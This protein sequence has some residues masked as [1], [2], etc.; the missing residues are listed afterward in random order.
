MVWPAYGIALM[1][2]W[3]G[4][5]TVSAML[6]NKL[7]VAG[8]GLL[9]SAG[10]RIVYRA[11][12]HRWSHRGA[13]IC[14]VLIASL[15]VGFVWDGVLAGLLG[16]SLSLEPSR[17]GAIGSGV[18]EFAG[19]FYHG[20]VL[21]TWSL[22]YFALRGDRS[23]SAEPLPIEPPERLVLR[24]GRRATVLD[25]EEIL[26]VEGAGDYVRVHAGPKR[27]LVRATMARVEASL[28]KPNYLRIHR[29]VIVRLD[30]VRELVP[31]PNSDYEVVLRD[32]TR[33]RAS[34]TYAARLQAA[35][36]LGAKPALG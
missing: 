30:Q 20:L 24:D 19:A 22:G 25:P 35:L 17:L 8:T 32:G 33:L 2:P 16:G 15:A 26:W 23:P 34:R 9:A 27:T 31:L 28:P 18:P 6:P 36:G 14:F 10:L 7:V 3:L 1:L 4:T 21:L 5:Y 13:L 29:S 12:P 11:V